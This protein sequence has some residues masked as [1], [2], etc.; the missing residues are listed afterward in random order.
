MPRLERTSIL[1]IAAF[2]AAGIAAGVLLQ[3][4]RSTR[5]DAPFVPPGSLP[6]TLLV[7][8]VVVLGLGIALRRAVTQATA[9]P[10]NPFHAV[11]LLAGARACQF[12]GSLLGGFGLGLLAQLLT[13]SVFPQSTTWLPMLFVAITGIVLLVAGAI[14]EWLC[15]IPPDGSDAER[16]EDPGPHAGEQLA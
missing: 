16:Q 8:A 5:G 4:F 9:R 6:A 15:R 11:R 14:A 1:T 3:V 2:G 12:A 7:L 10:V 13:R